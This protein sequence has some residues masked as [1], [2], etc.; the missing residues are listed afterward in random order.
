MH[1]FDIDDGIAG[2]VTRACKHATVEPYLMDRCAID[3]E[4]QVVGA[5]ATVDLVSAGA[6]GAVDGVI[7]IFTKDLVISV[8]I[9]ERVKTVAAIEII[10]SAQTVEAVVVDAA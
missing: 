2:N 1:V 3:V 9:V 6:I 4:P 8:A 5:A 7:I 10:I